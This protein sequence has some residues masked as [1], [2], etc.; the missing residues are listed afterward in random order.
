MNTLSHLL[1]SSNLNA[2]IEPQD[3]V[4]IN[5]VPPFCQYLTNK[6]KW[7]MYL[8]DTYDL[9]II[10]IIKNFE[11]GKASDILTILIKKSA[12]LISPLLAKLYNNCM[13]AG[14]FPQIFEKILYNRLNII[15]SLLRKIFWVKIS[16]DLEKGIH[17]SM[18]CTDQLE[19]LN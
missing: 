4:P 2:S 17:L 6:V 15:V 11:N 13:D 8:Y 5:N 9:Q 10:D 14:I 19:W 3:G 7:S 18:P 12:K 1:V 16:M